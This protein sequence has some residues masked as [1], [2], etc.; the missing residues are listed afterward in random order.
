MKEKNRN[1]KYAE[2]WFAKNGFEF[3]LLKQY[4]SKTVY[5]I[6]KDGLTYKWEL[7]FGVI[8]MGKY[9]KLCGESH[10]MMVELRELREAVQ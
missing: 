3:E 6:S 10:D 7:P 8:E 2:K 1:E 5:R 9:M 4:N